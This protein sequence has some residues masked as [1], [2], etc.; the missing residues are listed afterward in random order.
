M[1]QKIEEKRFRSMLDLLI[2][3]RDWEEERIKVQLMQGANEGQSNL[4][5]YNLNL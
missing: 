1:Y 3:F 2:K 4:E 5:E